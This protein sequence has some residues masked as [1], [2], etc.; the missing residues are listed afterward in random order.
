AASATEL[1]PYVAQH[2][3]VRRH[4]LEHLGDVLADAA[5]LRAALRAARFGFVQQRLARQMLGQRLA[6]RCL[7]R[8]GSG[9][10]CWR[11]TLRVDLRAT[12]FELLNDELELIDA[13]QPLRGAA[14]LHALQARDLQL[15]LLDPGA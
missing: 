14:E 9:A 6:R 12:R 7:P 3:P 2:L 1:R 5:H 8:R 4:V 10:A 13:R 15:E 11:G